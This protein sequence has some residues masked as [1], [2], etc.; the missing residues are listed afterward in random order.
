[1]VPP[2][3]LCRLRVVGD[4]N[5]G[6]H[7]PRSPLLPTKQQLTPCPRS[8]VML[9]NPI[10][11]IAFSVVLYRFFAHRIRGQSCAFPIPP[12]ALGSADSSSFSCSV[13]EVFLI[14]FFGDDYVKYRQEVPTR[15]LFIR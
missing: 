10:G 14:K 3:F 5:S 4:R 11:L 1:M 6:K 7:N 13:E 2:P 8:Q 12:L 9:A 15:I